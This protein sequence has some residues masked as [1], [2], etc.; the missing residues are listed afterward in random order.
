LNFC[1]TLFI[2]TLAAII[3]FLHSRGRLPVWHEYTK[4]F[5][6]STYDFTSDSQ[7]T[8]PLSSNFVKT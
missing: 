8:W 5:L 7:I 1:Q 4:C 3:Q 6:P 2:H